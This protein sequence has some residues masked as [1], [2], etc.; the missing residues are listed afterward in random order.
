[1]G[2]GPKVFTRKNGTQKGGRLYKWSPDTS[3]RKARKSS[4][5]G[6]V[7]NYFCVSALGTQ[8]NDYK[9]TYT[10]IIVVVNGQAE[11]HAYVQCDYVK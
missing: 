2:L 11:R 3:E 4:A 6:R 9:V 7:N 8:G 5:V 1:M 10:Y